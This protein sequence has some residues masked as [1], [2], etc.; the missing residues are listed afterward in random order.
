MVVVAVVVVAMPQPPPKYAAALPRLCP[1]LA[2]Q[3]QSP[4]VTHIRDRLLAGGFAANPIGVGCGGFATS[5]KNP[6][7]PPGEVLRG[8][9]PAISP[10]ALRGFFA[11]RRIHATMQ[12]SR[13]A[14]VC[15]TSRF[16]HLRKWT[17]SRQSG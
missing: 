6:H 13:L 7:T 17:K 8:C 9:Y 2:A 14:F 4:G 5:S 11:H 1:F 10:Y 3:Q 12:K 15:R 16:V